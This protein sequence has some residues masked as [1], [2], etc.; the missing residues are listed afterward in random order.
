M[1]ALIQLWAAL[2]TII[3]WLKKLCNN[4]LSNLSKSISLPVYVHLIYFIVVVV[5]AASTIKF[6]PTTPATPVIE[7]QPKELQVIKGETFGT[8]RIK[9]DGKRFVRCKFVGTEFLYMGEED[10]GLEYND[11]ENIKIVF[12][13]SANKTLLSLT[14]LYAMPE[15]RQTIEN[16]FE[17][18]K[19]GKFTIAIPPSDAADN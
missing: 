4:P 9:I 3:S 14:H 8:Q 6:W 11:Y 5:V 16:T 17:A 19:T 7:D 18:I 1:G 10:V 12:G 15:F 13:G 2:I